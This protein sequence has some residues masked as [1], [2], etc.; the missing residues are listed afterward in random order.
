MA[1]VVLPAGWFQAV[2]ETG[3]TYFY[4]VQGRVSWKPPPP[5]PSAPGE[6]TPFAVD[7]TSNKGKKRPKELTPRSSEPHAPTDAT[8]EEWVEDP[9]D[10][11]EPWGPPTPPGALAAEMSL[12]AATINRI[13]PNTRG[14]HETA[15]MSWGGEPHPRLG[16]GERLRLGY[17]PPPPF[18]AQDMR[19]A[20]AQAASGSGS[21]GDREWL[22]D[23]SDN[24]E[25]TTVSSEAFTALP[26]RL[27]YR[28]AVAEVFA[29]DEHSFLLTTFGLLYSW[30]RNVFGQLG[31]GDIESRSVPV[32]VDAL[33]HLVVT[34]LSCGG[35]HVLCLTVPRL[36]TDESGDMSKPL[37]PQLKTPP[38]TPKS[39][40][41]LKSPKSSKSAETPP[42]R[43]PL[44][45][46]KTPLTA[47][48]KADAHAEAQTAA[49]TAA[50]NGDK[51]LWSWGKGRDGQLGCSDDLRDGHFPRPVGGALSGVAIGAMSAG[52]SVSLATTAKD[53]ALYVWGNNS[54]GLLGLGDKD[55][56]KSA[57]AGARVAIATQRFAKFSMG[58]STSSSSGSSVSSSSSSSV[59]SSD[60]NSLVS[61]ANTADNN[62]EAATSDAAKEKAL[63][64]AARDAALL[65]EEL[66]G[67]K[68][69]RDPELCVTLPTLCPA[70]PSGVLKVAAGKFHCVA[71]AKRSDVEAAAQKL[72]K[73]RKQRW[74][75]GQKERER[76]ALERANAAGGN[77]QQRARMAT[78]GKSAKFLR[79]FSQSKRVGPEVKSDANKDS[80]SDDDDDSST[81][82][83]E[84]NSRPATGDANSR[85]S[86]GDANSRPATGDAE[87]HD[88]NEIKDNERGAQN[89]DAPLSLEAANSEQA[90]SV[91]ASSEAA[92]TALVEAVAA[93]ANTDAT[94]LERA[95]ALC[96]RG[97]D[98]EC[99]DPLPYP[100]CPVKKLT[101]NGSEVMLLPWGYGGRGGLGLGP[102]NCFDVDIPTVVPVP[103]A[104]PPLCTVKKPPT[105]SLPGMNS[106]SGKSGASSSSG[107]SNNKS[108][109]KSSKKGGDGEEVL[110]LVASDHTVLL[111]ATSE[112]L[113]THCYSWGA[114]DHGKCGVAIS[115]SGRSATSSSS[116]K[117]GNQSAAAEGGGPGVAVPTAMLALEG[118]RVRR[119]A[120][121]GFATM[122]CT[123]DG[124]LLVSGYGGNGFFL[125]P[126]AV[127]RGA[128]DNPKP[129]ELSNL[130][131]ARK[132]R[133]GAANDKGRPAR[134]V[135]SVSIGMRHGM[136]M[137]HLQA[138]FKW[139]YLSLLLFDLWSLL[140]LAFD[141]VFAS[142]TLP[143]H[144]SSTSDHLTLLV[145]PFAIASFLFEAMA[146]TAHGGS[147][148]ELALLDALKRCRNRLE[149]PILSLEKRCESRMEP[150]ATL[151]QQFNTCVR[152]SSG[153]Q[154]LQQ[155][156]NEACQR[157]LVGHPEVVAG[158]MLEQKLVE[159][160]AHLGRTYSP[161][162]LKQALGGCIP[163]SSPV[164][165]VPHTPRL[166]LLING[167]PA[168]SELTSPQKKK[169][170]PQRTKGDPNY[171]DGADFK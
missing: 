24:V 94:A 38:M 132:P 67:G 167:R 58:S 101:V 57:K 35:S 52:A 143:T 166:I 55:P 151:Q 25:F 171:D 165:M 19:K 149:P 30:G 106:N 34:S 90:A 12:V 77:N 85:P 13:N 128:F 89:E 122:A 17:R 157:S 97:A 158:E 1:D 112:G 70:L 18:Q 53:G 111:T 59:S 32:L 65:E 124:R 164:S 88:N 36:A 60:N 26:P 40:K 162:C 100:G 15:C 86:T 6:I 62:N 7:R 127:N 41:S 93:Q 83:S 87:A 139:T 42:P 44:R 33:S 11:G 150:A 138:F 135:L 130:T 27:G 5:R 79:G 2:N 109:K 105:S 163:R 46:P 146:L 22:V 144:I 145:L 9:N 61:T 121:G 140:G 141:L 64:D 47:Q 147:L 72:A 136:L 45:T 142:F 71:L 49:A 129:K 115:S 63:E 103:N 20:V 68:P 156:L 78:V 66:S 154:L 81:G 159:L 21:G 107:S 168:G 23:A 161:N 123:C 95:K 113:E 117:S 75:R 108:T 152:H 119:V 125:D 114:N 98:Q 14:R 84:P 104:Q 126:E 16:N 155:L 131:E 74:A 37:T 133:P 8:S 110:D 76:E 56:N 4:D 160:K 118:L 31:H 3:H 96:T 120:V 91:V 39:P 82:S 69:A 102:N 10:F 169:A 43:T 28:G 51:Q 170:A 148:R 50:A 137:L 153:S 73:K 99:V 29:A 92:T 80:D 134:D 48:M 116:S 54:R